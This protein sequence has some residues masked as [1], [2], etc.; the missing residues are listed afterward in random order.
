[1]WQIVGHDWA[2]QL[3]QS[4]L[5]H[6]LMAQAYLLTGQSQIGKTTLALEFA[7]ALNCSSQSPP[8]G[9]C[10]ACR[11]IDGHC[12]PDVQLVVSEGGTIKI[13]Q[14]REI[15]REAVLSPYEGA[16]RVYI[17]G[18]AEQ[19]TDEA[20]N[21]LLKTLEEPPA[22]VVL[23]LTAPLADTLLP[24]I[25][26]RCQVLNLRPV[27]TA[28]IQRALQERWGLEEAPAALLARL[29]GGRIGW[30]LN[31]GRDESHLRQRK[32]LLEAMVAACRRG[33]VFRLDYAQRLSRQP[34]A[35]PEVLNL[36]LGWWRDL[37]LIK[38]GCQELIVNVDYRDT[39]RSEADQHSL[40]RIKGYIRTIEQTIGQLKQNVNTR[41]ALETL[42]LQLPMPG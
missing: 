26:S 22:H 18:R 16:W 23:I 3:L 6:G 27:P 24:T 35:L 36:W 8:C 14:I 1:M 19:A 4:G 41:L 17:I 20:A 9:T 13:D 42:L 37:L 2:V 28:L 12:H 33:R 30:A 11:K 39:L 34:E 32:Q 38:S 31:A 21:C 10:L 40:I 25:V 5:S 15:R 7:K 29:A